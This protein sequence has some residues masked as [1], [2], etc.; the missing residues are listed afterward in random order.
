MVRNCTSPVSLPSRRIPSTRL[1]PSSR[2]DRRP[3]SKSPEPVLR[4]R[5]CLVLAR[6]RLRRPGPSA[7]DPKPSAE[8]VEFFEKKVRPGP[9]RAVRL[10]P[11]RRRSRRAACGS[12]R[13]AGLPQGRRQR[14]GRRPRRAGQEPAGRG[15]PPDRRAEDAAEGEAAGRGGRGAGRRGSRS[16]PRARDDAAAA[17]RPGEDALGVPAGQGPAGARRPRRPCRTPIDRVRRWRSSKR[18]G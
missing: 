18:R 4:M 12:T 14:P 6:V 2:L 15:G 10:V 17:G 16:G 13:Q 8:A 3:P 7:A 1:V 5:F 9:G 11:R